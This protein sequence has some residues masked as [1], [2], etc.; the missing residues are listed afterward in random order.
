MCNFSSEMN[1]SEMLYIDMCYVLLNA[2]G[3]S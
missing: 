1:I 2:S 3:I